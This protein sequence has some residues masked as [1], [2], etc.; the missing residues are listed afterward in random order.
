VTRERAE[1]GDDGAGDLGVA[2]VGRLPVQQRGDGGG[3][4][5]GWGE[6]VAAVACRS[7]TTSPD[8]SNASRVSAIVLLQLADDG[9][10]HDKRRESLRV[11]SDKPLQVG[12]E[13]FRA[14]DR[15]QPGPRRPKHLEAKGRQVDNDCPILA[16]VYQ[17][18]VDALIPL[19]LGKEEP[20]L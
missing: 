12:L 1:R 9:P 13:R 17:G 10:T 2:D 19:R 20:R 11:P 6:P 4:D 16:K 14:L 7:V 15:R 8:N 18:H 5:E 3:A